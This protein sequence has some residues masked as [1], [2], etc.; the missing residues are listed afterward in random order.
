VTPNRLHK[1]LEKPFPNIENRKLIG[2]AGAVHTIEKV[3]EVPYAPEI[4]LWNDERTELLQLGRRVIIASS[5]RYSSWDSFA[6]VLEA[7][8]NSF[9]EVLSPARVESI[10][11]RIINLFDLGDESN[12][13]ALDK[14][15]RLYAGLPK[16]F[17]EVEGLQISFQT[18][19]KSD[20]K[21][22]TS[23]IRLEVELRSTSDS[24]FTALTDGIRFAPSGASTFLLDVDTS[25]TCD[26]EPQTD[27]I[28]AIA[29]QLR[30]EAIQ[31]LR[32][33]VRP[34]ILKKYRWQE[35]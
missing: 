32:S 17:R 34:A 33:I 27:L 26:G 28:C 24:D 19:L 12:E 21:Q 29:E 18:N 31:T 1:L 35:W 8:T 14:F 11:C 2:A 5:L 20:T 6:R 4:Q 30:T 7:G 25:C 3:D 23:P 10:G 15:F 13:V 16:N 9:V 22:I